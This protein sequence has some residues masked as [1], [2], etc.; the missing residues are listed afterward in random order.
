MDLIEK[1]KVDANA[2][3][4]RLAILRKH[5]DELHH[6]INETN[7]VDICGEHLRLYGELQS[8]MKLIC[9]EEQQLIMMGE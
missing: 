1:Q 5:L 4:K 3:Y 7:V 2:A 9:L 8:T 6:E